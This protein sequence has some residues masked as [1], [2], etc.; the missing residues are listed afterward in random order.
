MMISKKSM[1]TLVKG[2]VAAMPAIPYIWKA[3][4]RTSI[5]SYV[6]GGVGFAIAGGLAAVMLLSPRTR[7]RALGMAKDTYGKVSDKVGTY[8]P[9][10]H[11][12]N[13]KIAEMPLSNGLSGH[14]DFSPTTSG[15]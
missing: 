9:S 7:T 15:L 5:T 6:L 11:G 4:Q 10:L 14:S 1:D 2:V 12:S 3:R 8:V 13:G